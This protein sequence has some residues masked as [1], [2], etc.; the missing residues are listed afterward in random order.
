[1]KEG[2]N[3]LNFDKIRANCVLVKY[4][5]SEHNLEDTS[6][7]RKLRLRGFVNH[8]C[9]LKLYKLVKYKLGKFRNHQP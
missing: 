7:I 1:M 5:W 4:D 2:V 3:K 9:Y 8:V 6:S